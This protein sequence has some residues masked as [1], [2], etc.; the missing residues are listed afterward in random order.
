MLTLDC[1]SFKGRKVKN[2]ILHPNYNVSAKVNQ[3]VKEFYDYD[4]ALIQ[5][6]KHV[7]ISSRV[8]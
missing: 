7:D 3:G 5:L 6:E 4:V 2:F 1:V 8:R